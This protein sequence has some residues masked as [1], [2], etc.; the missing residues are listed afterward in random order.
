[1][2]SRCIAVFIEYRLR[3]FQHEHGMMQ[4]ARSSIGERRPARCLSIV[5]DLVSP[6]TLTTLHV[7]SAHGRVLT[8]NSNCFCF[9]FFFPPPPPEAAGPSPMAGVVG[10]SPVVS[11]R[12][13]R[14]PIPLAT[15]PIPQELVVGGGPV[16]P[17]I[18]LI[19][20]CLAFGFENNASLSLLLRPVLP[21][22][23][24]LGKAA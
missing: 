12:T 8:L 4:D 16:V 15:P 7:T 10:A 5:L 3:T 2:A 6:G 20:S 14:L 1:M 24:K 9:P 18:F 22:F 21:V 11:S 17:V 23:G 19:L 13:C